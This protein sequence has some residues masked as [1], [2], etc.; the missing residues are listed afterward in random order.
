MEV[1]GRCKRE[2][3]LD[4]DPPWTCLEKHPG[5]NGLFIVLPGFPS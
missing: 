5:D 4:W 2:W 1:H 3:G